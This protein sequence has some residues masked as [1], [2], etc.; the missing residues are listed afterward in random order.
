MNITVRFTR[1]LFEEVR[2]DLSRP[3]PL[4]AERV[5]F[6]YGRLASAGAASFLVLMTGYEPV[7]D[8]RYINDPSSGARI[9]NH[10]IRGAMQG[11]LDRDQGGFHV[12]MHHWAGRPMLSRMD[13]REI[14]P[15]VAGLRRVGL[16]HAHGIV[17]LHEL[18]CAAWVW[19][20]GSDNEIEAE[21]VSV[22][23]F[24]LLLFWRNE[25]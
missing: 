4:A 21:S 16:A 25:S 12:H 13:A 23:G 15:V 19:L 7:A 18:E 14:P 9:D 5:G 1:K 2:A 24:P 11:V 17:L 10:A 20:P 22:V 8:D 6:L 3:H